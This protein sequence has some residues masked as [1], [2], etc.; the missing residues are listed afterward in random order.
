ML[1]TSRRNLIDLEQSSLYLLFK[2]QLNIKE[3]YIMTNIK[4]TTTDIFVCITKTLQRYGDSY[5]NKQK[6]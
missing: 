4:H 3:V 2:D 5:G 1:R 6:A